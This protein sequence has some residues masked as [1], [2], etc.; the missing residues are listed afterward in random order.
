M[1]RERATFDTKVCNGIV[2]SELL[3]TV[4]TQPHP[5]GEERRGV[6]KKVKNAVRTLEDYLGGS[7]HCGNLYYKFKK[8]R[9]N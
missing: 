3:E 7:V 2:H 5:L 4:F 1:V 8:K 6:L 9:A